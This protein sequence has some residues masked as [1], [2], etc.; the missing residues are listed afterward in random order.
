MK[1]PVAF[2]V[3][4]VLHLFAF[5]VLVLQTIFLYAQPYLGF[6]PVAL[7]ASAAICLLFSSF[8][9]L[10][11]S[12]KSYPPLYL[13]IILLLSVGASVIYQGATVG[14]SSK[15][16]P[17]LFM[18][19]YGLAIFL[20]SLFLLVTLFFKPIKE[21]LAEKPSTRKKFDVAM[22]LVFLV[23]TASATGATYFLGQSQKQETTIDSSSPLYSDEPLCFYINLNYVST[24]NKI[25][26]EV[27]TD[28]ESFEALVYYSHDFASTERT[29]FSRVDTLRFNRIDGDDFT[30]SISQVQ[31]RRVLVCVNGSLSSAG[32]VYSFYAQYEYPHF[33]GPIT[34]SQYR[35]DDGATQGY[36]YADE[37]D[38]YYEDYDGYEGYDTYEASLDDSDFIAISPSQSQYIF[39]L[40]LEKINSEYENYGKYNFDTRH[41]TILLEEKEYGQYVMFA[42]LFQELLNPMLN[43]YLEENATFES[44]TSLVLNDAIRTL[45]GVN[46]YNTEGYEGSELPF[47]RLNPN[48]MLWARQNLLVDGETPLMDQTIQIVYDNLFRRMVWMLMVS[49]EYISQ[50]FDTEAHAYWMAMSEEGF[51]GPSYLYERYNP[52]NLQE[53]IFSKYYEEYPYNDEVYY[54]FTEEIA[55]GF[56]LRRRLDGSDKEVYKFLEAL[57]EKYDSYAF[58]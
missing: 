3:F 21:W 49:H 15:Q 13:S 51:Y 35:Y 12:D 25:L 28:V 36:Q 53:T 22:T 45:T 43:Q 10:F 41:A 50:D 52:E 56:W 17:M 44:D 30:A 47:G 32:D 9:W 48:L 46:L 5:L 6:W 8:L 26:L 1:F 42:T 16:L 34:I 38:S 40:I 37:A 31:A 4:G 19:L 58:G 29:D 27:N 54:Y 55:I 33:D 11:A 7:S 14:E 18:V 57:M 39:S 20:Y 24:F 23:I 2:R